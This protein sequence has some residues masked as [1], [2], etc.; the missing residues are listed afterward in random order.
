MGTGQPLVRLKTG[1]EG[2][3]DGATD[4]RSHRQ[5]LQWP[6]ARKK[7]GNKANKV[8]GQTGSWDG[9]GGEGRG[10]PDRHVNSGQGDRQAAKWGTSV[11][12]V[13]WVEELKTGLRWVEVT[14]G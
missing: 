7:A 10:K 14:N 8:V 4:G 9:N 2:R 1:S 12:G 5:V 11:A 3:R 6:M 13:G